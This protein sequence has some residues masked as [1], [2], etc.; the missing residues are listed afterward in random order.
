MST[1]SPEP[2]TA[3]QIPGPSECPACGKDRCFCTP[4]QRLDAVVIA[5]EFDEEMRANWPAPRDSMPLYGAGR[6]W[7]K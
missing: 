5:A 4:Q 3:A 6:G 2:A 1:Y 7:G